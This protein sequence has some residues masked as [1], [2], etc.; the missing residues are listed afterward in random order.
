MRRLPVL[1]LVP[2]VVVL[3]LV[4]TFAVQ[5]LVR[6]D[7]TP[8]LSAGELRPRGEVDWVVASSDVVSTPAGDLVV[9]VTGPRQKL[10]DG[11]RRA[12]KDGSLIGVSA[13][14]WSSDPVTVGDAEPPMPTLTMV[15]RERRYRLKDLSRWL[16]DRSTKPDGQAVEWVAL[17]VVPGRDEVEIEVAYDGAVA[18]LRPDLAYFHQGARLD[19]DQDPPD[20]DGGTHACG[21]LPAAE[22][23]RSSI[24]S[25]PPCYLDGPDAMSYVAGLGWAKKGHVWLVAR[26]RL[27]PAYQLRGFRGRDRFFVRGDHLSIR[28]DGA[29]PVRHDYVDDLGYGT[30]ESLAIFDAPL[31]SSGL[32]KGTLSVSVTYQYDEDAG[33]AY[34]LRPTYRIP[35][36]QPEFPKPAT[37][38]WRP[39][40]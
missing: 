5:G 6:R 2:L 20:P 18:T 1:W 31:D 16:A 33:R 36:F 37:Y 29:R 9:D 24:G 32:L 12:P 39:A 38:T 23:N 14:L 4:V 13:M 11:S 27:L 15:V 8:R 28:L 10:P 30:Q 7:H 40:S 21:A 3:T 26:V 19:L 17:P 25:L 34:D 22:L 35:V